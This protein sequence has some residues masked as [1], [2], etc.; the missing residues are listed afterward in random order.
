MGLF[1]HKDHKGLT[2]AE[3]FEAEQHFFDEN[4]REEL[5]NH[6]R[7]YFEKV[8][9]ENGKIFKEDLDATIASVNTELKDHTD[10]Q[11]EE[12]IASIKAELKEHVTTQLDGQFTE[13]SAAAKES[14][15]VALK[16]LTD[17]AD[18]LKKQHEDL[19]STLQKSIANQSLMLESLFQENMN[20]ITAVK[21]ANE[22]AL[23]SL[24]QSLDELKAQNEQITEVLEKKIATQEEAIIKA[25]EGNMAQV[26]E[27]YLLDALSD[28]YD[29]KAQLPSIIKQMELNKQAMVDDMKL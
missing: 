10:K 19:A 20:K 18:N 17:S 3:A 23:Q 2:D 28:Q 7:L 16:S 12:A 15:D 29:L 21:E 25:F 5:R 26:V 6:G 8:I 1:Q 11:L 22:A 14:Q 24:N 13:F 9:K 4:F 27:H